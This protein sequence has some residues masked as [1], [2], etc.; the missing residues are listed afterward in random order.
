MK[1]RYPLLL[2]WG[3][4]C[5]LQAIPLLAADSLPPH[6][7]KA[8][9]N[10]SVVVIGVPVDLSIDG[11]LDMALSKVNSG[12]YEMLYTITALLGTIQAHASGEF[13]NGTLRPASYEQTVDVIKLRQFHTLLTFDWQHKLL[14]VNKDEQQETLPLTDRVM[15]PLSLHLLVMQD[16]Q[17][18]RKPNR[19]TLVNS[20][21][22]R[23][24]QATVEGEE[25]LPTPLGKLRTLRVSTRRDKPGS[26]RDTVLWFAPEL[27]YLPVRIVHEKEGKEIFRMLLEELN[28]DGK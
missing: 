18:G 2:L 3:L 16:L 9:Y 21:S 28:R 6:P 20:T 24:Y 19:Y 25:I 27:G 22:L 1:G 15:D 10:G 4:V 14:H 8:R 12:H 26:E 13:Q 11:Q 5:L 23:T 7:F 17:K